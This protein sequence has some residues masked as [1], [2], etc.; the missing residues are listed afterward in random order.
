M[1][2]IGAKVKVTLLGRFAGTYTGVV[3]S[4]EMLVPSHLWY[5]KDDDDVFPEPS[6]RVGLALDN[7]P[8]SFN[9]P[10]YFWKDE[11]TSGVTV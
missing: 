10:Y 2:E 7:S 4:I 8:F 3:E 6:G 9:G 5:R 11:I 1:I